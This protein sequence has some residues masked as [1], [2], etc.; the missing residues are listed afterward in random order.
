MSSLEGKRILVVEDE[1][2]VA[3]LLEEILLDLGCD[4][5]G[6]AYT[7]AHGAGLARSAPLDAAVLDV[8]VNG[9]MSDTIAAI[10]QERAVP[11]AF[12][13]GYGTA[14]DG[15][16]GALAPVLHKPYPADKLAAV[17]GELLSA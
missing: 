4:V 10:L 11:Y 12:A 6:P 8:N 3:L 17:L 9:E 2:L 13:T 7:I 1:P 15:F 5:I 16:D 14:P